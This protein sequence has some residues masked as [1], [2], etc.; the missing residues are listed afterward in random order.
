MS[1][2]NQPKLISLVEHNKRET[3]A[4][5]K[6]F[7]TGIACPECGKE[8]YSSAL[9]TANFSGPTKVNVHCD[10]CPYTGVMLENQNREYSL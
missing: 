7:A 2:D 6:H 1:K 9:G 5:K 3:E 10:F 4:Y 8:L